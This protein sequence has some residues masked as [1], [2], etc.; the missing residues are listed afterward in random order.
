[1]STVEAKGSVFDNPYLKNAWKGLSEE[2][3]EKYRKI[4]NYMY[5]NV[6][7]EGSGTVN[8]TEP[9]ATEVSIRYIEVSLKSGL[10]P[11][12]LDKRERDFM[13]SEKGDEW[14]KEYGYEEDD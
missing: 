2:E 6:N 10:L 4:G 7:Y 8:A 3:K 12:D 11:K 13:I 9:P 14:F 5:G 1:M